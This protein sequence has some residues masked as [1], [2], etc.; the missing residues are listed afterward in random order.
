MATVEQQQEFASAR[1]ETIN[2]FVDM[3]SMVTDE[4]PPNM[5]LFQSN[6]QEPQQTQQT[7]QTSMTP[8]GLQAKTPNGLPVEND[9]NLFNPDLNFAPDDSSLGDFLNSIIMPFTPVAAEQAISEM[10]SVPQLDTSR[11][12]LDFQNDFHLDLNDLDLGFI[13]SFEEQYVPM[14]MSRHLPLTTAPLD[15]RS[16][17]PSRDEAAEVNELGHEAFTR[18]MWVYS[19][20]N[21]D[22]SIAE[23][24]HLISAKDVPQLERVPGALTPF[25]EG[26]FSYHCRDK[27]LALLL[28]TWEPS[29]A[30]RVVASFPK[31][32]FLGGLVNRFLAFHE[33]QPDSW[34]HAPTFNPERALPALL[35]AVIAFG[36]ILHPMPV[37]QKLG[38][39]LQEATRLAL[40]K[41]FESNN[42]F[43]RNLE[44]WQA[45]SLF[46]ELGLW[47]GNKRK[48]E[49]A[50]AQ[51]LPLMTMSRR[52]GLFRRATQRAAL[53]EPNDEG[54]ELREKWHAWAVA[55]S[56]KRLPLSS[57]RLVS[58]CQT[59]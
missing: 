43:T 30:Y 32:E 48:C 20:D 26:H 39:A 5:P 35:S 33:S 57:N 52:A 18:S 23:A 21:Y 6:I 34:F 22:T 1:A 7:Q 59:Y 56:R 14:A 45:Y 44:M 47:S 10:M 12:V 55:E 19:P 3:E 24:D 50:E 31:T 58:H 54:N 15:I 27:V 9:P 4:H 41:A 2:P 29:L 16:E 53:P 38:Y 25:R 37:I 49:I 40:V 11:D 46:L 8:S 17:P 42:G 36:A 51:V 13:D 28:T